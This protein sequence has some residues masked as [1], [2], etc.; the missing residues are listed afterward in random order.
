MTIDGLTS[1]QRHE[2][3]AER[4]QGLCELCYSPHMVQHHHIIHGKGKRKQCET[5]HSL[6]A[7]C[8]GCHYGNKGIHGKDGKV[9]D[10]K[11]KQDLQRKYE[12]L[13]L[14][15]EELQYWLGGKFY[16]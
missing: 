14:K 6:I 10:T 15:G 5:V 16:L 7:L 2:I 13:G 9:L 8:W 3:V 4:S 12:E 11:L 1:K